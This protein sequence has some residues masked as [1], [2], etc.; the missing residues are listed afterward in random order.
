MVT[1]ALL[2]GKG[3]S[4]DGVWPGKQGWQSITDKEGSTASGAMPTVNGSS[5]RGGSIASKGEQC[6]WSMDTKKRRALPRRALL[7]K[8]EQC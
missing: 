7:A 8:G 6:Q 3:S 1:E 2:M 4:A 5:A